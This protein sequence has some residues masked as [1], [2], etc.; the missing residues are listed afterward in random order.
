MSLSCARVV[1]TIYCILIGRTSGYVTSGR[2][3][4][5]KSS[6]P[7]GVTLVDCLDLY[8]R[9]DMDSGRRTADDPTGAGPGSVAAVLEE[10][11]RGLLDVTKT[12]QS[13][14]GG[15]GADDD[16]TS[17]AAATDNVRDFCFRLKFGRCRLLYSVLVK[18]ADDAFRRRSG[19]DDDDDGEKDDNRDGTTDVE[20]RQPALSGST[21]QKGARLT[22]PSSYFETRRRMQ[23]SG[24][25][26]EVEEDT[27]AGNG[28][29]WRRVGR[30]SDVASPLSPPPSQAAGVGDAT[31]GKGV[32]ALLDKYKQWRSEHGYGTKTQRWGRSLPAAA[33]TEEHLQD[34]APVLAPLPLHL[35]SDASS[36][37][38]SMV[39]GPF[40]ESVF[41]D[42]PAA[43]TMSRTSQDGR[44]DGP[45]NATTTT[46]STSPR[47]RR[48]VIM[49]V[50]L[51]PVDGES[52][53]EDDDSVFRDYLSWRDRLGYGGLAGRWG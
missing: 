39:I 7:F 13:A 18:T 11:K 12:R 9:C 44:W 8:R 48:S 17:A 53:S 35:L 19:E 40:R 22:V 21:A 47:Q 46:T 51:E 27:S 52:A 43:E 33:L 28:L 1:A 23:S 25:P 10:A 3:N 31:G 49:S 24:S 32:G 20:R 5:L 34:S 6:Y 15:G 2:L 30:G 38:S 41:D 36:S 26:E 45:Q 16:A 42:Q 37:S 14:G 50:Q 29:R 4:A